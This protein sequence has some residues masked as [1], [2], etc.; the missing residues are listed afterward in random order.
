MLKNKFKNIKICIV[1]HLFIRKYSKC[2]Y[3]A[4]DYKAP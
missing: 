4:R 3:T 1:H 2:V